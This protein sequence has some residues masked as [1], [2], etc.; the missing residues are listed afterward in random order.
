VH[1]MTSPLRAHARKTGDADAINLWAGQAHQL[2]EALPAAE[3]TRRLAADA[4][5]AIAA[6]AERL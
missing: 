6:A 4:R 3:I 5:A 1:Y 2:A